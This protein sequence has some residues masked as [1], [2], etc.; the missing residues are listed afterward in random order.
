MT[1]QAGPAVSGRSA[2]AP[3][4]VPEAIPEKADPGRGKGKAAATAALPRCPA[5]VAGGR[6]PYSAAGTQQA[7]GASAASSGLRIV[8]VSRSSP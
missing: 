2:T 7:R 6:A 5:Q 1:G 8:S 3:E 4:M